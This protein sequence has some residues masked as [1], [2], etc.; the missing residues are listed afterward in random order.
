VTCSLVNC[1]STDK[2][3]SDDTVDG[4]VDVVLAFMEIL[5]HRF[6][7][8]VFLGAR[9]ANGHIAVDSIARFDSLVHFNELHLHLTVY[10]VHVI[11]EYHYAG[12]KLRT[13][14]TSRENSDK[15]SAHVHPLF[16]GGGGLEVYY[17]ANGLICGGRL[18]TG[19][20]V[21]VAAV[22][23]LIHCRGRIIE[24]AHVEFRKLWRTS[25]VIFPL[26]LSRRMF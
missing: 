7:L 2:E 14:G 17:C 11:I 8:F 25:I 13:K 3:G 23:Q 21:V 26:A 19:L 16:V 20:E 4:T 24:Q 5:N 15:L 12:Q 1:R 10:W 22:M 18:V 9:G 6:P